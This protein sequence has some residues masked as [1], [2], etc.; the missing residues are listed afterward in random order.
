MLASRHIFFKDEHLLTLYSVVFFSGVL[1]VGESAARAQVI[2]VQELCSNYLQTTVLMGAASVWKSV[3]N[4]NLE[5]NG[6]IRI[7][8]WKR[9]CMQL[10][11]D[12]EESL[13]TLPLCGYC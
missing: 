3:S 6:C 13:K 12:C 5:T 1:S 9:A 2:S 8:F 7:L 10:M 11:S 4:M